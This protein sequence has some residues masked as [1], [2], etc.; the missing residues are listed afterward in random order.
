MLS[1]GFVS[2]YAEAPGHPG[3]SL[4]PGGRPNKVRSCVYNNRI[5]SVDNITRHCL[6]HKSASVSNG[7]LSQWT[8]QIQHFISEGVISGDQSPIH[9][10]MERYLA[11]EK[12]IA[13]YRLAMV[14][15]LGLLP[16]G[17]T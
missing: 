5:T 14:P 2:T 17:K 15:G 10:R 11:I 6:N 3:N 1:V 9:A 13:I 4:S 12:A 7:L 16:F 8:T